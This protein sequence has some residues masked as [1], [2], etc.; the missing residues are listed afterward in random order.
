MR[1]DLQPHPDFPAPSGITV[2]VEAERSGNALLL[3]YRLSGDAGRLLLPAPAEPL[4]TDGLWRHSCFEAFVRPADSESYV[5]LNFSPSTQWA[6]YR[7]DCYR[8][9]MAELDAEPRI[10][11]A[12]TGLDVRV[13][14]NLSGHWHVG[15]CAVLEANDGTLSYWA[16]RHPQ[17]R[18]DFHHRD[19][20]ALELASAG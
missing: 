7:F 8:S 12:E 17:G 18:P 11:R 2:A 20:F 6:A 4:R 9:G 3:R 16:L 15:L 19:C 14:L 5:E 13:E 1:A 10:A